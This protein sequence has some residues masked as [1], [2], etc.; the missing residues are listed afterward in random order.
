MGNGRARDGL[1]GRGDLPIVE[2][3]ARRRSLLGWDAGAL[4]IRLMRGR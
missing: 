3:L 4:A 1:R 2:F